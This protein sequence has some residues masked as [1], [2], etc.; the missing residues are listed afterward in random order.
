[1]EFKSAR[2]LNES[3]CSR[4]VKPYGV[5]SEHWIVGF[6]YRWNPNADSLNMVSDVEVIVQ[7][8]WRIASRYTATGDTAHIGSVKD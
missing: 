6:L 5:Y 7:E 1:M 2:K 4:M 3:R 8:K